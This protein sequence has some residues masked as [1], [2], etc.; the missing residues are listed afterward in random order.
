MHK[1]HKTW[2]RRSLS[3]GFVYFEL[4]V[5]GFRKE[6]FG[7]RS[8]PFDRQSE[9]S[10]LFSPWRLTRAW[11]DATLVVSEVV[12]HRFD[13]ARIQAIELC[14]RASPRI[15]SSISSITVSRP[16]PRHRGRRLL[17]S[18]Q[19]PRHSRPATRYRSSSKGTPSPRC[20]SPSCF[21]ERGHAPDVRDRTTRDG[22]VP[23]R[24]ASMTACI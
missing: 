21:R 16:T 3:Q 10:V 19:R 24:T 18:T 4:F 7:E 1:I 14:E 17:P 13:N 6:K 12:R 11:P 8:D 20:R 23:F 22:Y 15:G 2:A 9:D 5:H